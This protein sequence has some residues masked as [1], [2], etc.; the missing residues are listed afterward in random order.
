M[1]TG[2]YDTGETKIRPGV[3]LIYLIMGHL[4]SMYIDLVQ[5]EQKEF[6]N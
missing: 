1:M 3:F 4:R 2:T 5:R 6:W